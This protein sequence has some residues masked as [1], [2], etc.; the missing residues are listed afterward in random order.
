MQWGWGKVPLINYSFDEAGTYTVLLL[1][2]DNDG[3]EGSTTKTVV[4]RDPIPT[5]LTSDDTT[6]AE[7]ESQQQITSIISAMT[8]PSQKL[9]NLITMRHNLLFK[10]RHLA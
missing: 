6:N 7:A 10:L 5:S 2:V 8:D 4:V 9:I 3:G 1:V